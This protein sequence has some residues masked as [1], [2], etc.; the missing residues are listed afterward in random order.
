MKKVSHLPNLGKKEQNEV[1]LEKQIC[2]FPELTEDREACFF[3]EVTEDRNTGNGYSYSYSSSQSYS[4]VTMN[5][6]TV[7]DWDANMESIDSR[8]GKT[9]H[10]KYAKRNL[11]KMIGDLEKELN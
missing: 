1:S 4:S 5:G 11:V 3:S 8:D 9:T 10:T 6:K 7:S 2:F